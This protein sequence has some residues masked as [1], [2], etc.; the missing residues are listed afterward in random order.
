M[1]ARRSLIAGMLLASTACVES[2][3][4]RG[5]S[6][7]LKLATGGEQRGLAGTV[8]PERI[9]VWLLDDEGMPVEGAT[10][11]WSS[12]TPGARFDPETSVSGYTGLATT[13]WRLGIGGDTQVAVARPDGWD[14]AFEITATVDA[15]FKAKS[16]MRGEWTAHMCALDSSGKA[17]CWGYG[18]QGQLGG[19]PSTL[20]FVPAPVPVAGDHRFV[21]LRGAQFT[22]CGRT[23]EGQ[24]WCWGG[25]G[26][27]LGTGSTAGST[28]PVRA[29][30]ELSV[31][32]F[33]VADGYICAVTF[34]G[35][36]YCWGTGFLGDGQNRRTSLT[37]QRVAGPTQWRRIGVETVNACAV[38]LDYR[39]YCWGE[40]FDNY[41][42]LGIPQS[43]QLR[44][45]TLASV[46]PPLYD[47][48][49]GRNQCG[50][51]PMSAVC[52]GQWY[53][54]VTWGQG[55][56]PEFPRLGGYPV[57]LVE[58]ANFTLLALSVTGHLWFW[59]QPVDGGW[60][61]SPEPVQVGPPVPWLDMAVGGGDAYSILR[62][63]STV[64][65][66]TRFTSG[67]P[68]Y[69]TNGFVVSAVPPTAAP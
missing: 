29:V 40:V 23:L 67:Y 43:G 66:W 58:T 39:V 48:S 52:W 37:P 30:P 35:A 8:L 57:Q 19:G 68:S 53:N 1:V 55:P 54:G 45:P 41:R 31:A 50:I 24:L 4:P 34:D 12:P 56:G 15:A 5:P 47:I 42:E 62:A 36:A 13:T 21:E 49:M 6:V 38:A 16:L 65:R 64:Y 9:G 46:V 59:G 51:G 7:H 32:D 61:L 26:S 2:V 10:I 28:V 25:R 18:H 14:D 44:V 33:D 27:V 20:A 3:A 22:T 11:R 69:S 60:S 17:Y 63:D